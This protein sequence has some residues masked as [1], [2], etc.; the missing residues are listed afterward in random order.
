MVSEKFLSGAKNNK[1]PPPSP[2]HFKAT[3][4]LMNSLAINS[5][6]L[7]LIVPHIVRLAYLLWRVGGEVSKKSSAPYTNFWFIIKIKLQEFL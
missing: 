5:N 7:R 3:T 6:M 4:F 2:N 1:Y